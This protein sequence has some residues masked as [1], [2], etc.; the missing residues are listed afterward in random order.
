MSD[1]FTCDSCLHAREVNDDEIIFGTHFCKQGRGFV[2][3]VINCGDWK[4]SKKEI[5]TF[6]KLY[7]G[8]QR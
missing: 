8:K 4:P 6:P 7:G 1:E 5:R 2:D 3:C